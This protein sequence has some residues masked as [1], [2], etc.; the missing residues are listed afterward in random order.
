MWSENGLADIKDEGLES[1]KVPRIPENCIDYSKGDYMP[2]YQAANRKSDISQIEADQTL[3]LGCDENSPAYHHCDDEL[4]FKGFVNS[5][6]LSWILVREWLRKYTDDVTILLNING[7]LHTKEALTLSSAGLSKVLANFKLGTFY[8]KRDYNFAYSKWVVR[9]QKAIRLIKQENYAVLSC[10]KN[11]D[12]LGQ[13]Q[14]EVIAII[15]RG[16][17]GSKSSQRLLR[18]LN[19]ININLMGYLLDSD[20]YSKVKCLVKI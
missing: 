15:A 17:D 14:D 2:L 9:A 20:S 4:N 6:Q 7:I 16:N 12:I 1:G 19:G 11:V 8:T 18:Y 10:E 3:W 5:D 13:M